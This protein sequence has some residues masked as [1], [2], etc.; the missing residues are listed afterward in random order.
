[1]IKSHA[2]QV[3]DA[4]WKFIILQSCSN[5]IERTGGP[6][7]APNLVVW[8]WEGRAFSFKGQ[9]GLILGIPQAGEAVTTFLEGTHR[10]HSEGPREKQ[11]LHRC[12]VRPTRWDP[13]KSPG[14]AVAHCGD[15]DTGR[16][17]REYLLLWTL[18]ETHFWY[19]DLPIQQLVGASAGT[20]LCKTNNRAETQPHTST[21]R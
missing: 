16:T 5:R 11:W 3:D 13:R 21:E 14:L 18:L 10:S 1:M 7:Q 19:Q 2:W 8:N 17:I 12:L 9:R 6:C 15:K 4:K 20:P